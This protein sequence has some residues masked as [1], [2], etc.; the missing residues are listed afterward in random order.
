MIT[1]RDDMTREEAI[2]MAR[3]LAKA[4]HHERA[5]VS[6][7]RREYH[8]LMEFLLSRADAELEVLE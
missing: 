4:L 6:Q 2:E 3:I 1:V 5:H 7:L 8:E